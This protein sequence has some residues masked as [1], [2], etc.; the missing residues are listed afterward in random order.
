MMH[1]LH[2]DDLTVSQSKDLW[3]HVIAEYEQCD[4]SQKQFCQERQI[5]L[6]TFYY[7]YGAY[8]KRL[9]LQQ[10]NNQPIS[11]IPLI[12][13]ADKQQENFCITTSTGFK[14]NIPQTFD[15]AQ[16]LRI[17]NILSQVSC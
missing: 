6:D 16:L 4:I 10:V 5:K 12:K 9:R 1:K 14:L 8:K 2:S 11:F 7:K 3:T 13:K 17:L 15:E